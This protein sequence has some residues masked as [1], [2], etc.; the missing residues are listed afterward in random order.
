[1][2]I[3]RRQGWRCRSGIMRKARVEAIFS[4]LVLTSHRWLHQDVHGR[5]LRLIESMQAMASHELPQAP[6][7]GGQ[8]LH[9]TWLYHPK[10]ISTTGGSGCSRRPRASQSRRRARQDPPHADS[11]FWQALGAGRI[12]KRHGSVHKWT[13][14]RLEPHLKDELSAECMPARSWSM[15]TSGRPWSASIAL[16]GARDGGLKPGRGAGGGEGHRQGGARRQS[17]GEDDAVDQTKKLVAGAGR[18]HRPGRRSIGGVLG[19]T[20]DIQRKHRPE[21]A[22]RHDRFYVRRGSWADEQGL[23]RHPDGYMDEG[24]ARRC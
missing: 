13:I 15:A 22:V 3:A 2:A 17:A 12:A 1:M 19:C 8:A 24:H 21:H 10:P 23:V 11:A 18:D 7:G 9:P 6:T 20:F 16:H 4:G 14:D 5:Q